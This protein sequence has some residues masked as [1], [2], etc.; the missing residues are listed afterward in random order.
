MQRGPLAVM[1]SVAMR[2]IQE[3][4]IKGRRD[5]IWLTVSEFSVHSHLTEGEHHS[6]KEHM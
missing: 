5:L 4:Q 6:Y 1:F 3:K 2:G